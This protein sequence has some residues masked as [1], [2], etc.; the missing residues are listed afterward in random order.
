M[1]LVLIL[2]FTNWSIL[3]VKTLTIWG[4]WSGPDW[5]AVTTVAEKSVPAWQHLDDQV[6]SIW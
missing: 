3:S 2:F 4:D 6:E 5:S 1:L